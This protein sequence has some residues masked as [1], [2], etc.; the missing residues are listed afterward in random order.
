MNRFILVNGR[1]HACEF[2]VGVSCRNG[3][4]S[5]A[6][7]GAAAERKDD[8][9]KKSKLFGNKEEGWGLFLSEPGPFWFSL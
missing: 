3:L 1:W 8:P 5:D 7:N 2:I 9:E 4:G 6:G